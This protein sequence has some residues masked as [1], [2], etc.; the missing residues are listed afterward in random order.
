MKI[1][2][3]IPVFYKTTRKNTRIS[4]KIG[5]RVPGA[6]ESRT[7]VHK[8]KLAA[9]HKAVC[10]AGEWKQ[11]TTRRLFWEL[12]KKHAP[13]APRRVFYKNTRKNISIL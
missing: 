4:G 3:K 10:H 13:P 5:L 1:R 7:D 8:A 2:E 12:L 9:L 11:W 6:G